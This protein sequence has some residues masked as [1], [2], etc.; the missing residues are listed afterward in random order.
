MW[1][2][3]DGHVVLFY[4]FQDDEKISLMKALITG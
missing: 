4:F 1:I 2:A 3:S